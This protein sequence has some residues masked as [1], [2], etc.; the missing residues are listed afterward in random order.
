MKKLLTSIIIVAHIFSTLSLPEARAMESENYSLKA[1]ALLSGSKDSVSANADIPINT[2]GEPAQG[3]AQSANYNLITGYTGQVKTNPPILKANIPYRIWDKGTSLNNAFDL[4]DYFI[5]FDWPIL[6]YS[7]ICNT[8]INIAI[9]PTTHTVSFSQNSEFAGLETVRFI[10]SDPDGNSTRSKQVKLLVK[11]PTN[12]PPMIN[13]IDD[14]VANEGELVILTPT[15]N[16]VD[17]NPVT[18]S[19]SYPFDSSGRWQTD[20]NDA[21]EYVA[22]VTAEDST[23]LEDTLEV[24]VRIKNVNRPPI[25][26]PIAGIIANEGEVVAIFPQGRDP[27]GDTISYASDRI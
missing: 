23:G 13:L 7:V 26:D 18:F 17:G 21:G 14:I 19:Y 6:S 25:L 8:N 27:D 11:S 24:A 12:N 20:Y 2:I 1:Q 10:A 3:E 4:D 5:S 22:I 16:D 9:D 15:A